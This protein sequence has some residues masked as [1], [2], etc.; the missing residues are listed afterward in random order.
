M[1]RENEKFV[2]LGW[3]GYPTIY[4]DGGYVLSRNAELVIHKK[5]YPNWPEQKW[6]INPETN[7]KLKIIQCHQK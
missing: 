3:D 2:T 7:Q 4:L 1:G 5:Y 6:P